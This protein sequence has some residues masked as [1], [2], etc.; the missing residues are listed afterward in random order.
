MVTPAIGSRDGR[1]RHVVVLLGSR[2]ATLETVTTRWHQVVR[3]WADHPDVEG[4]T[5]VDFPR[6]RPGPPRCEP[7]A[8][9]LP[10][11]SA[12]SVTVPLS[13]RRVWPGDRFGWRAVA[14]RIAQAWGSP[15]ASR[16]VVAATPLWAPLL[17]HVRGSARTAFDAYDDWRA[18]PVFADVKARIVAGYRSASAA[19][20]VTF[21]S[22][23]L[24]S[25]LADEF[26]LRGTVVR[27]GADL[28]AFANGGP[29]PDG[30]PDGPFAVYAG[31]IQER[32]DLDLLARSVAVL[33]TVVAGPVPDS[34]RSPLAATGVLWLGSVEPHLLPGLF[35]KAAVGLLPHVVDELTGSMDPIKLYE[36]RAAGLP[37]VATPAA[38]E[39]PA[40]VRV[41]GS[42]ADWGAAVA[43]AVADGRSTPAGVRDWDDVARE[44]MAAY[45]GPTARTRTGVGS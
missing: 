24:A 34:L 21:G 37:V 43:A 19:D 30:L 31:V 13:R 27:N 36:Y 28:A 10:G 29:S 12:V 9:W 33:P 16:L 14:R 18:L 22:S 25:R 1:P 3:R 44:L 23:V 4:V 17:P 26:G 45:T 38:V 35:A 39:P 42:R 7:I 20:A 5:V 41:V 8:S 2:W 11:V 32:V 15:D 6:F 40:G